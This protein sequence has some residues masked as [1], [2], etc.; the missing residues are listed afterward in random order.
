M[1]SNASST[2]AEEN[3]EAFFLFELRLFLDRCASKQGSKVSKNEGH[4][5]K[6]TEITFYVK[7]RMNS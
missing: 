5:M 6:D 3:G 2:S 4:G 7:N 1:S